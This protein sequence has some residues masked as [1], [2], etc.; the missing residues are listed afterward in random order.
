VQIVNE[1]KRRDVQLG[2]FAICVAGG[3]G[4]AFIESVSNA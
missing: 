1:M 4:A 2:L 3:M